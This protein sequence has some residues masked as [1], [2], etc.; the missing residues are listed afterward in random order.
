MRFVRSL[1]FDDLEA[2]QL[3]SKVHPGAAHPVHAAVVATPLVLSGTLAIDTKATST[4]N[5]L[6]GSM[7]QVTPV[8]GVLG[9]LGEVHGVWTESV[10]SF[11]EYEAPDTIQLRNSQG[12]F[13]I[14]FNNANPGK[15]QKLGHGAVYYQLAQRVVDGTGAYARSSETGTIQLDGIGARKG[16]VGMTLSS[17]TTG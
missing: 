7:S 2:R 17:R 12:A 16:I 9:A 14:E 15:A 11:G 4:I 8:V 1:G 10:D 5:N 3:L 13:V 6:D